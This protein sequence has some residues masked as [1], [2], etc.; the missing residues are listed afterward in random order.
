[1]GGQFATL[2]T[3]VSAFINDFGPICNPKVLKDPQ[4][5]LALPPSVKRALNGVCKSQFKI[6]HVK[7][8]HQRGSLQKLKKGLKVSG[9]FT[10]GHLKVF[11]EGLIHQKS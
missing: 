3:N 4:V 11:N 6:F 1:L 10:P 9:G 5:F 2:G 7:Y 8:N